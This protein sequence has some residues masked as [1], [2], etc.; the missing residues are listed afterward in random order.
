[1]L[2]VRDVFVVLVRHLVASL[3]ELVAEVRLGLLELHLR[4]QQ[5]PVQTLLGPLLQ[6]TH[7]HRYG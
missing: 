6:L 1:M 2:D 4:A 7:S 3:C 5:P